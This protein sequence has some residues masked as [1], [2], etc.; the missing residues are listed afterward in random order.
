MLK[1][2]QQGEAP[3]EIH[4]SSSN[5]S[6][7]AKQNEEPLISQ[8]HEK[9]KNRL[10]LLKRE[11]SEWRTVEKMPIQS[12]NE[13]RMNRGSCST[14]T[15]LY[16]SI[17]ANQLSFMN[18]RIFSIE[19]WQRQIDLHSSFLFITYNKIYFI[20]NFLFIHGKFFLSHDAT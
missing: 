12:Q 15:Q 13:E 20:Y 10:G 1:Y 2:S 4:L 11:A 18:A 9:I 5:F 19:I 14:A 6:E 17:V 7:M 16:C 3:F 8:N